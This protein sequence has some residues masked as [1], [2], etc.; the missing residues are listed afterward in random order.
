M[1]W[2]WKIENSCDLFRVIVAT[3]Q[4]DEEQVFSISG[5]LDPDTGLVDTSDHIS[6]FLE[7]RDTQVHYTGHDPYYID[8]LCFVC[9]LT[10]QK[11]KYPGTPAVVTAGRGLVYVTLGTIRLPGQAVKKLDYE[12]LEGGPGRPIGFT[13]VSYPTYAVTMKGPFDFAKKRRGQWD[14]CRV[15]E[16]PIEGLAGEG[17]V[18]FAVWE[19]Q[20]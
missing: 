8:G 10:R 7:G 14:I 1:S 6:G 3:P 12:I 19:K 13:P 4:E 18:V 5:T 2:N 20:A 9:P 11:S 16:G 15:D 17:A